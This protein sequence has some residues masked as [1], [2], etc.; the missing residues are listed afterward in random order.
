MTESTEN[1]DR[2]SDDDM[3]EMRLEPGTVERVYQI[4]REHDVAAEKIVAIAVAQFM[5]NLDNVDDDVTTTLSGD[6]VP[7]DPSA[8]HLKSNGNGDGG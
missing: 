2:R 5:D 7:D 4:R 6:V 8:E 1:S 3:I